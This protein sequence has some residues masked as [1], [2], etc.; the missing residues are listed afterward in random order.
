MW[1]A[2]LGVVTLP[3]SQR[4][5]KTQK[6]HAPHPPLY[7]A[8]SVEGQALKA[9]SALASLQAVP[10]LSTLVS[11]LQHLNMTETVGPELGGTLFAPQDAVR[12]VRAG[13]LL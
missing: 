13:Q 11:Y 9:P 8:R 3:Q 7:T 6:A 12:A 4:C 10:Y 2:Y 1:S 5:N